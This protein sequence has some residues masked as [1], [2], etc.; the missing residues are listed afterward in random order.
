MNNNTCDA[1]LNY[2]PN[3]ILNC[4]CFL[5]SNC[6]EVIKSFIEGDKE[7]CYQCDKDIILSM[8]IDINK[9]NII[10]QITKYNTNENNL[11]ILSKLKVR[12]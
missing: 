12:I 6:Y 10:N 4:G 11:I 7:K 1:C 2:S 3:F 9:K 8:T 5:C